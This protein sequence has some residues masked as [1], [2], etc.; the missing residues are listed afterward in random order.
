MLKN[1][2]IFFLIFT[3]YTYISQNFKI[4]LIFIKWNEFIIPNILQ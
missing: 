3:S 4:D 1:K 2:V